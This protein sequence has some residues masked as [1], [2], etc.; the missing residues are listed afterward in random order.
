MYYHNDSSIRQSDL[1]VE[2]VVEVLVEERPTRTG[3]PTAWQMHPLIG[4]LCRYKLGVMLL[5]MWQSNVSVPQRLKNY[6]IIKQLDIR[7]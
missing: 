3:F 4:Q 2:F 5:T 1:L 7:L 6:V